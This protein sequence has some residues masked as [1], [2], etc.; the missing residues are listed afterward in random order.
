MKT[1]AEALGLML[2]YTE[3]GVPQPLRLA[4]IRGLGT[5][6]TGQQT[7]DL[8][9]ILERLTALSGETFF[10][11]QVAVASALGQMETPKAIPILQAL[12]TQTPD[13]RVRRIADEAIAK[14]RKQLGPER[15][16][17]QLQQ[18]LDQLRQENQALRSRLETLE[19]KTQ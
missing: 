17:K 15:G 1:S 2:T 13:G 14:V 12:S 3:T 18:D 8:E 10:L 11:T 4:A 19:S 7:P 16:I 6:S 5:I 9:R